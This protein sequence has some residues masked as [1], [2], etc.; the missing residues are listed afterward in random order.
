MND[1]LHAILSHK[2]KVDDHLISYLIQKKAKLSQINSW[3]TDVIDRLMSFATSGKTT[4]GS[5]TVYIYS[6][7][8]KRE[9]LDIYNAAAALELFHSGFLIHDDIM[10]RDNLRRGRPSIWEQYSRK[11]HDLHTGISQAINTGDLCFFMAQELLADMHLLGLVSRELQPVIVAQMQDA[12]S[13]RIQ[14]L[15]K[16]EVLSLYRYKTARYTFSLSMTVGATLAGA[17]HDTISLFDRLGESMGLLFQ[18]RDDELSVA[19]DSSI[20]GKPTGSDEKNAKLTLATLIN[21]EE[22]NDLKSSLLEHCDHEISLLPIAQSHKDELTHL[23]RYCL[24]RDK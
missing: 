3:G 7:F 11:T 10:D 23:V 8:K 17:T 18:I 20:T 4:R 15:S 9:S 13:G 16:D 2:K 1:S 22:L 19:G 12:V 5:L 21:S 6:L 14:S 24:T